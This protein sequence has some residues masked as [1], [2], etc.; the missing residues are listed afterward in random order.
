MRYL[1]RQKIFSLRTTF[2]IRDE[3]EQDVFAATGKFFSLGDK[4][5]LS[6]MEGREVAFIKQRLL[7]LRP[8]YEIHRD[9][10]LAASVRKHLF[11]FLRNKFTIDLA[12]RGEI[13][14]QG[15]IWDHEYAFAHGGQTIATVSKK[16]F[17]LT[18]VYG[19]DIAPDEDDVLI[20]AVT[21]AIDMICHRQQGGLLGAGG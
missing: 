20:L 1:M 6:D 9:G 17:S 5:T 21:V 12:G 8:L 7:T 16:W 11:S 14:V 19:I 13:E 4:L 15:N 3:Y 2:T 10:L 18:D